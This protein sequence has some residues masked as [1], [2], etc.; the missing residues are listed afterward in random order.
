[1]QDMF[2]NAKRVAGNVAGRA[3]WEMDKMQRI[4]TR[5]RE[6]DLLLRERASTVE[7]MVSAV[8]DMEKRGQITNNQLKVVAEQLRKVHDEI[9]HARAEIEAIRSEPYTAGAS[10]ASGVYPANSGGATPTVITPSASGTA[11][12]LQ[13]CP[14]CGRPSPTTASFCSNCGRRLR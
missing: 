5:Q 9:D 8:L 11:G 14:Q 4:N 6:L 7:Q 12:A 10:G 2:D 3:A 13:S 1:M